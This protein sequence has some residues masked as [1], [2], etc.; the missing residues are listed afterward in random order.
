MIKRILCFLTFVTFSCVVYAT[1]GVIISLVLFASITTGA[2]IAGLI[3]LFAGIFFG[4]GLLTK[5]RTSA[6]FWGTV[7]HIMPL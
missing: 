5:N 1:F 4:V 2:A 7:R 3:G 6:E